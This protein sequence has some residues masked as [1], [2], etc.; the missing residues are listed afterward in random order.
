MPKLVI[1]D[2]GGD[3]T[4]T[5]DEE[6]RSQTEEIFND[7]VRNQG[8]LD[9]WCARRLH[10][11]RDPS[12]SASGRRTLRRMRLR[13]RRFSV[14]GRVNR[15]RSKNQCSTGCAGGV[16]RG[17]SGGGTVTGPTGVRSI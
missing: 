12:A 15:Q 17:A 3:M 14:R 11:M 10:R 2:Q 7:L 8:I 16:V 9:N 4:K 1:M 6:T 13:S 5:W